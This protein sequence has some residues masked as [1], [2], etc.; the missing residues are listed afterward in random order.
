MCSVMT[1]L[2]KGCLMLMSLSFKATAPAPSGVAH[3]ELSWLVRRA[4]SF[5]MAEKV[6]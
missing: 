3:L 4:F 5:T 2:H 1:K 6:C